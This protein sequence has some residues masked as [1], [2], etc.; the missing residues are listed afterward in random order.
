MEM[1]KGGARELS[2][3]DVDH[4]GGGSDQQLLLVVLV[5]HPLNDDLDGP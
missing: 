3:R 2:Y 5:L 4:C 1:G